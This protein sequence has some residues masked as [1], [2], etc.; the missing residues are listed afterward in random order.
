MKRNSHSIIS[1]LKWSF[2]VLSS[3]LICDIAFGSIL[4]DSYFRQTSGVHYRIDYVINHTKSDIV[5]LGSSRA[6]HH[7]KPEVLA[8]RLNLDCFNAGMDGGSI[9]Y[10]LALFKAMT[11]R[12]NPGVII[13]DM[14]P[15]ALS[16][17][18][19]SYERLSVLNPYY[20]THPEIRSIVNLRSPIEEFKHFSKIYPFNSMVIQI[21]MG[22]IERDNILET[23]LSGYVPLTGT[24]DKSVPDTIAIEGRSVD[25]L[26][27]K[28][29]KEIIS[30]CKLR[31]IDLYIISSPVFHIMERNYYDSTVADIC[32]LNGITFV[33]MSNHSAF[34]SSPEFFAD[35]S[36]LNDIGAD[37]FSSIIA[38]E[39]KNRLTLYA[40]K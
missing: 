21:V 6:T 38:D 24:I 28:A 32:S 1:F 7:Y 15:H 12:Y 40:K 26:K 35:G 39:L 30:T 33:D 14:I 22:I 36:H 18:Q 3:I 10:D 5:I 20:K 34:I 11:Q 17:E 19:S 37:L 16:Y 23:S 8:Q 27:I 25:P 13:I 31:Q 4:R 2:Y 9:L 29:L